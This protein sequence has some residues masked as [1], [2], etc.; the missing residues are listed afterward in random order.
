MSKEAHLK[1]LLVLDFPL[2]S[3]RVLTQHIEAH[4]L[5]QRPALANSHLVTLLHTE[6]RAHVC[7]EVLV[8]LLITGVLG[9]EVKVFAADDE[10]AVH[11][12]GNDS[13]RKNTA[14]DGDL[15]GEW[16]L[17]VCEVRHCI[18]RCFF[19]RLSHLSVP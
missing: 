6:C 1:P 18:S 5:A 14:T 3:F 7:S 17:A 4:S 13:A 11:L 19:S 2:P 8:S 12:G 10:R 9:D 16:A 15:A